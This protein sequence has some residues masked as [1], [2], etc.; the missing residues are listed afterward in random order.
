MYKCESG[1]CWKVKKEAKA[2]T[3]KKQ[4]AQPKP[5]KKVD[6]SIKGAIKGLRNRYKDM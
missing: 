3:P 6:T 4:L 1:K 2:P 5:K